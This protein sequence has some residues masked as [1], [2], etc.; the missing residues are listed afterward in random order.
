M[1][2]IAGHDAVSPAAAMSHFGRRTFGTRQMFLPTAN[3]FDRPSV[4]VE[5]R[6]RE[7]LK[8]GP[9]SVAVVFAE[10]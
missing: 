2:G 6:L 9:D 10:D 8:I 7:P 1:A 3:V 5:R 4:H